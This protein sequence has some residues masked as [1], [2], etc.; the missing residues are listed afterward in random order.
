MLRTLAAG[1]DI[2]AQ[3]TSAQ[4][5]ARV[6]DRTRGDFRGLRTALSGSVQHCQKIFHL[7]DLDAKSLASA[8]SELELQCM[9]VECILDSHVTQCDRNLNLVHHVRYSSS[10]NATY[11]AYG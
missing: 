3:V 6:I 10:T 1:S 2:Q 7:L 4:T 9:D 5:F 8:F 11:S